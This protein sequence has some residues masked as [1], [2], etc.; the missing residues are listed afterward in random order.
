MF[1]AARAV[2]LR[3]LRM[4][5]SRAAVPIDCLRRH[6][7]NNPKQH[8][9][10]PWCEGVSETYRRYHDEEW[11]VPVHDDSLQ[12][13]FLILEGAQAGLSWSTVLHKREAYRE[14]FAGFDVHEVTGTNM[15]ANP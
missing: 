10:C 13:E 11:G 6:E 5:L 15:R 9:T 1:F 2:P 14:A 4:A 7:M 3:R 8:Q 12:F